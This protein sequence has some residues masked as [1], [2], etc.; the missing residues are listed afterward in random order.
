[1]RRYFKEDA[2]IVAG[3]TGNDISFIP[4][5]F[6]EPLNPEQQDYLYQ[7]WGESIEQMCWHKQVHGDHLVDTDQ[8][9]L[10]SSCEADALMTTKRK[11]AIAIRTADCVPIFFYD[12]RACRIALAHAGWRG[13]VKQIGVKTLRRMIGAGSRLE[14][15]GIVLGPCIK[16]CCYEVGGEVKEQLPSFIIQRQ[17]RDYLDMVQANIEAM[18]GL[19]IS[20]KQIIVDPACTCCQQGWFSYRRQGEGAGRMMSWMMLK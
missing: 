19:G 11:I 4:K 8:D 2:R 15:I 16:S 6:D 12:P 5:A 14:D 18:V 1:M 13:T 10:S 7:H 3:I 17:G 20:L 9:G